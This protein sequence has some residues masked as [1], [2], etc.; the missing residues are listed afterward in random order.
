M[1]QHDEPKNRML[2]ALTRADYAKLSADL[3]P[4]TLSFKEHVYEPGKRIKHV[5]FMT[6]G[7]I[8]IVTTLEDDDSVETGTSDRKVWSVFPSSSAR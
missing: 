6:S 8:S 4:V 1:R 7:M 3:T 5:Y 2:Q